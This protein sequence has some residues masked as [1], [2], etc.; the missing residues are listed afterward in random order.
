MA[1]TARLDAPPPR[2]IRIARLRIRTSRAGPEA[3]AADRRA[4]ERELIGADLV[5]PELPPAALLVVRR[6]ADPLPCSLGRGRF[7]P[8]E[9]WERS[10]REA[11]DRCLRRADRPDGGGRVPAGAEAVLF[12]DPSELSACRIR[13]LLRGANPWWAETLSGPV[14]VAQGV[15][16]MLAACPRE[17]PAVLG[18]LA[19]WGELPRAL[20]ALGT[21][22][23]R[24]LLDAIV[25][26]HG[27][28]P[29]LAGLSDMNG[30]AAAPG[31]PGPAAPQPRATSAGPAGDRRDGPAPDPWEP[32]SLPTDPAPRSRAARALLGVCFGLLRS[33]TRLRAPETLRAAIR[34]WHDGPLVEEAAREGRSGSGDAP[35]THGARTPGRGTAGRTRRGPRD[36]RRPPPAGPGSTAHGAVEPAGSADVVQ[37][38]APPP[39]ATGSTGRAA[40]PM[41]SHR[42]RTPLDRTRRIRRHGTSSRSSGARSTPSRRDPPGSARTPRIEPRGRIAGAAKGVRPPPAAP[43][44]EAGARDSPTAPPIMRPGAARHRSATGRARR[45]RSAP[46]TSPEPP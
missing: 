14:T 28:P 27:L 34:W 43:V 12:A 20:E 16:E 46:S 1:A 11:L 8:P 7:R 42:D 24:R 3:R 17:L 31:L 18:R 33:P 44:V 13:A 15:E 22:G 25:S 19:A 30:A 39:Q 40:A 2:E 45:P 36:T 26:A 32:W 6:L 23:V 5:L 4:V 41:P 37:R 35:V 29:P 38:R 21:R 9:A 10:V